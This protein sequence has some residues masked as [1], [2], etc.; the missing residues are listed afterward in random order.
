[1]GG[2]A[3]R[4]FDFTAGGKPHHTRSFEIADRL[5]HRH[6][7]IPRQRGTLRPEH[8]QERNVGVAGA[9]QERARRRYLSHTVARLDPSSYRFSDTE[10]PDRCCTKAQEGEAADCSVESDRPRT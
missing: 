6:C 8:K 9:V 5:L 4:T 7:G 10:R 2:S 1:M 3:A